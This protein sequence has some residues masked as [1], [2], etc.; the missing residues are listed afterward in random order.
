MKT[1]SS[2]TAQLIKS[3][4]LLL[5]SIALPL[6]VLVGYYLWSDS[7]LDSL[8]LLAIVTLA[9]AAWLIVRL[10]R[11]HQTLRS[12]LLELAFQKFAL[13][14]HS[15]VSVA[16]DQGNIIYANDKFSEISQYSRAELLGQN[17]RILNSGY[18]PAEFFRNMWQTICEGKV[19]RGEIKNRC[20][21]G[22]FYWVDSTIVPLLGE[23]GKPE[24]YF[25]IRTDITNRKI[26]DAKLEQQRAFYERISET[27]GE[28]LYVQ[29]ANGRCI[30]MNSE[31]ERLL[32]WPRQEFIGKLVHPTIHG[33]TPQGT[34]LLASEC[35]IFHNVA[36]SG[37]AVMDDQ[38]F[39]RKDG[40]VFPVALVSKASYTDNGQMEALV[41][42][43]QDIS[44]RINA[45]EALQKSEVR[46]RTLFD[47]TSDAV[48]LLDDYG[49]IDCNKAALK[50]FGYN[51]R[52]EFCARRFIDIT[53]D[54][55]PGG[56]DQ[57]EGIDSAMLANMHIGIAKEAGSHS[58]EW[59]HKRADDGKSFD[60]EVLLNAMELDG[61]TILQATVRDITERKQAENLLWQAK[62]AAEQ[63]L[64]VKG[65]FLANMSHEIRTPMNGIIGMTELA[66]DTELTPEQ[67][68]YL[69]LV[70]SSSDSLLHIVNDILDFSKIESGKL[71]IES[72][73]FSLEHMLRD[74]MKS[75][76]AR[77]HQKN[78]ELL[79]HVAPDVPDRL[80]GDPGRLRQVIV[81]L[82][83]NA[84]K[85]TESGEVK[86]SV[87]CTEA[88]AETHAQLKF[89]VQDTGIGIP[90]DKFKA[91]FESF[92]QADT[93]TTR[94]YGG[95]GLGLTISAQLV[96]LM[97]GKIE[98]ESSVGKGSNFNFTLLMNIVSDQPLASYQG[99]GK[100]AGMTV[101]VADDNATNR[102]LLQ[103]ILRN[104]KMLPTVVENGEQALVELERA[105]RLGKPYQV[106]LLDLQMTGMD[107][108]ELAEKIRQFPVPVRATVMMLTSEGQRGHAARCRELGI[109]SYLMK[110]VSQYDLLDAIM[111]ALGEPH[112]QSAGLITRH[113][114]RETR[115]K[116]K[117]LLAEDNV[118]NQTL[119]LRLLEKLGHQV[120]L[121]KNGLEAVRHW[122]STRFDAILMDVD[123]PVMN[124]YEATQNIRAQEQKQER[125][126]HTPIIAMTA[127]AMQGAREECLRYGMDG[128]LTKPIDT[129]ALWHELDGLAQVTGSELPAEPVQRKLAV[130]DFEM[131]RHTMDDNVELFNEIVRLFLEDA[132]PHMQHI[133]DGMT[134]GD[135]KAM[136]HSAHTLKGMSGIFAAER[137]MHAA[138]RVEKIAVGEA[139][140]EAV[141]ELEIAL[142]ELLAAVVE[143]SAKAD[144]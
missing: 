57:P 79:L 47:S 120:T 8:A 107:G 88:V 31:A 83:G 52:E 19:W 114:L 62:A 35:K 94:K 105:A 23:Q 66:L 81:N 99:T 40:S 85:F 9:Y 126:A 36:A 97:G 101:L 33:V 140:G 131:A 125:S 103:E 59:L 2:E 55:Q 53:P 117:L 64:S 50:M 51:T 74:T 112:S 4:L 28:G 39:M 22:S 116:L 104:W 84:I 49:F 78:L 7:K 48:M 24:R 76:A 139:S 56:A 96:E 106:A 113:S 93:S 30:Y 109:A 29:D 10:V 32:G 133:K 135:A 82:V 129:E 15:I 42:A 86:V 144:A 102:M 45:E 110:P 20:K 21:N 5:E 95:T 89:S 77:A 60:A 61:R 58:F 41:V 16:D 122:E 54:N 12:A 80:L 13:D 108:F 46:L 136:H 43:F 73:E 121:A 3:R 11:A 111:T 128:Y 118:V 67:R 69:S 137:T 92:S 141:A 143:Y 17:H 27:L 63:A 71:D 115:R 134:Q 132:P 34:P 90:R 72:I 6:A 142:N 37:E 91:I 119:A 38:V 124:G 123:M 130:A 65:D 87:E 14:Q 70:K 18:H 44:G 98:L 138:E 127:H 26:I 1:L 100:I 68:E 25:S 75:L